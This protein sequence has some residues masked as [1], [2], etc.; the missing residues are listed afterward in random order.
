MIKLRKFGEEKMGNKNNSI[1]EM[2]KTQ[3]PDHFNFSAGG[4]AINFISESS[5][6]I[7]TLPFFVFGCL[8]LFWTQSFF[9]LWGVVSIYLLGILP[10][11]LLFKPDR[12]WS[13]RTM[14]EWYKHGLGHKGSK[15]TTDITEGEI[16][17][18]VTVAK[19][20]AVKAN[21][22]NEIKKGNK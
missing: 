10:Y 13:E 16:V 17:Q 3:I 2:T 8:M 4:W 14:L 15:E 22:K 12:T 5:P 9:L 19:T 11:L 7:K 20:T 1:V 18:P 6:L 21:I